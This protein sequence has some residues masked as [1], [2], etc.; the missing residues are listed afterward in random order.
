M[1][2]FLFIALLA[3]LIGLAQTTVTAKVNKTTVGKNESF[4]LQYSISGNAED[5][6]APDFH[7][8]FKQL[9]QPSQNSRSSIVN[10][11][12]SSSLTLTYE[13]RPKKVGT[14]TIGPGTVISGGERYKSNSVKIKVTN[15]SSTPAPPNSDQAQAEKYSKLR[16]VASPRTAYVGQ[17]IK[18]NYK[19]LNQSSA[20]NFNVVESPELEGF[21]KESQLQRVTEQIG[22]IDGQ[23][24]RIIEFEDA[25]LVPQ[26]PQTISG[27]DVVV[28]LVTGVPT[29]GRNI[30]GEPNMKNVKHV[31]TKRLPKITIKP[32]PA[33]A[34]SSFTGAVGQFNFE[35]SLSRNELES[36]ESATLTVK[37]SGTGNTKLVDLPE[38]SIPDELE[39]YDPKYSEKLSITSK[40]YKGF[41]KEEYLIIPRYKGVYKIPSLSFSYFDL[42]S[43]KYV[44]IKSEPLEITVLSGPENQSASA[45]KAKSGGVQKNDVELLNEDILFIKTENTE[46]KKAT[47]PFYDSVLFKVLL[48][49]G[50]AGL[51]LPW[52]VFGAK[53]KMEKLGVF[54]PKNVD[55]KAIKKTLTTADANHQA[56][57]SDEVLAALH[58]T[59]MLMVSSITGLSIAES[60]KSA[61]EKAL[62]SKNISDSD[63][64]I[65]LE[66]WEKI[67]YA[68]F[69][70]VKKEDESE[71][72][73]QLKT[74]Y[75]NVFKS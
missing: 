40:G 11:R 48:Y 52:F 30:W 47:E 9:G 7:A 10:G 5:F 1:K 21:L 71:M 24:Y 69:A 72:I 13:L 56:G 38:V 18:L 74:V 57:K 54:K 44:T 51:I 26:K 32:L 19:L 22:T 60:E 46:L 49:L 31:L 61:V 36:D 12:M 6:E 35:V 23:R 14:F 55:A 53:N 20:Y 3:P 15:Q 63:Q 50:I 4:R 65:L 73:T 75:K 59:L 43:E 58:K 67:E 39:T 8:N 29:G 27:K 42:A 33:N 28:E 62:E 37:I 66:L 68:R 34:P 64:S 2:H 25:I 41:K 45:G 17:P 70:P 16:L